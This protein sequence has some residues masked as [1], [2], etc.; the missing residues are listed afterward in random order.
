MKGSNKPEHK[1]SPLLNHS[2]T[3]LKLASKLSSPL[4]GPFL[5]QRLTTKVQPSKCYTDQTCPIK[6]NQLVLMCP[7][8]LYTLPFAQGYTCLLSSDSSLSLWGKYPFPPPLFLSPFSC[9]L[10]LLSLSFIPSLYSFTRGQVNL[11]AENLAVV[12]S[13]LFTGELAQ[14]LT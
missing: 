11:S 2:I 13:V 10:C 6:I 14:Q 1:S 9:I 7:L 12:H 5:L 3:F 8:S 4:F